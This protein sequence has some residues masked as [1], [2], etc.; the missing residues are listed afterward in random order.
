VITPGR[1]EGFIRE[2]VFYESKNG[3]LEKRPGRVMADDK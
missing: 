3:F 1:F 2:K